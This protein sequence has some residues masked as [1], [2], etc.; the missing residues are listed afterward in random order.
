MMPE[1]QTMIFINLTSV[2]LL[3]YE[4]TLVAKLFSVWGL[5]SEFS[6]PA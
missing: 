3:H 5:I 1:V 6:L 4:T 2:G